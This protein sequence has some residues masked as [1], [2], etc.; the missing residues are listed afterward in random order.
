MNR[1]RER[2]KEREKERKKRERVR[3]R[4]REREKW[5]VTHSHKTHIQKSTQTY[6]SY[7]VL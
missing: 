6:S 1:E 5:L 2:E 7:S 4:E 3:E